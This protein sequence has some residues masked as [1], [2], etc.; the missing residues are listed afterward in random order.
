MKDDVKMIHFYIS[1]RKLLSFK[2]FILLWYIS[3]L[4]SLL[5]QE[6]SLRNGLEMIFLKVLYTFIKKTIVISYRKCKTIDREK[7]EVALIICDINFCKTTEL[8][9]QM[10]NL[11][12]KFF[13]WINSHTSWIEQIIFDNSIE[14]QIF[15]NSRIE[16]IILQSISFD[17]RL[18]EKWEM[19]NINIHLKKYQQILIYLL[20][21]GDLWCLLVSISGSSKRYLCDE[22]N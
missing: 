22:N 1:K 15:T 14:H 16:K 2:V 8:M 4:L 20:S 5:I 17:F 9:I 11:L 21:F 18:V 7:I 6:W 12:N 19:I 10:Q 13:Q 3:F